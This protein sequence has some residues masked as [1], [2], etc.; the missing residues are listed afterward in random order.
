MGRSGEQGRLRDVV[1]STDRFWWVSTLFQGVPHGTDRRGA[2]LYFGE[3]RR[4]GDQ[5]GSEAE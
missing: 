1:R 5:G 4:N 3:G 2:V